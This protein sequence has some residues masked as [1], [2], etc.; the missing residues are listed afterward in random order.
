MVNVEV[1]VVNVEIT[2]G[3]SKVA[4]ELRWVALN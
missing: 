1:K 2:V 4:M 3:I